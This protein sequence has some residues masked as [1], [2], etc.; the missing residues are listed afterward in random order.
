MI[1]VSHWI[2]LSGHT[3]NLTFRCVE[4]DVIFMAPFSLRL[5]KDSCRQSPSDVELMFLYNF[6]SSA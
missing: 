5:D 3:Q 4:F 2:F 1:V 6:V